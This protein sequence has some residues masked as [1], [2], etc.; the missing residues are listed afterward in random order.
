MI[1]ALV[2]R[3]GARPDPLLG[4]RI[5]I[6]TAPLPRPRRRCTRRPP[7]RGS[8]PRHVAAPWPGPARRASV[9]LS[10]AARFR[11]ASAIVVL[12]TRSQP[13]AEPS[14]SQL[15]P[16]SSQYSRAETAWIVVRCSVPW[17]TVLRSSARVSSLA[18]EALEARPEADV[19]VRRVLVL[20][21]ADALERS[22]NRQSRA[23]E[24]QLPRE[25]RPVQLP[26]GEDALAHGRNSSSRSSSAASSSRTLVGSR[27][28]GS[29]RRRFFSTFHVPATKPST[30]TV[31]ATSPLGAMTRLR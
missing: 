23:L 28:N 11:I 24:E 10:L 6:G 26:L 14:L 30:R 2:L 16:R 1:D 3:D 29:T 20:D 12:S 9:D 7:P 27:A 25:Q 17:T 31:C 15:R 8:R 22:R 21:A 19:G 4:E 5:E 18:A 13:L